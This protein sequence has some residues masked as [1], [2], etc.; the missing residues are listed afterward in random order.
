[1]PIREYRCQK[2]KHRFENLEK[3]SEKSVQVC[4]KCG[5]QV[6]KLVSS[7]AIQ[8][9]GSGFYITDYA[10]KNSPGSQE[11][12]RTESSGDKKPENKADAPKKD[13]PAS[14]SE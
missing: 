1:M 9:K 7:P 6:K 13:T 14:T 5:G 12:A 4:P 3:M 2:C 11:S 8:F 10:H